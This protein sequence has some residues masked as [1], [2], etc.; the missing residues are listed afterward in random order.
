MQDVRVQVANVRPC[1]SVT[2]I[3]ERDGSE[4]MSK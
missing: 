2:V 4:M 1:N 3:E